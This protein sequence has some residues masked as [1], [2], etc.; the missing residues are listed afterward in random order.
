L[1]NRILLENYF[2]Q[3]DLENQINNFIAYWALLTTSLFCK[4]ARKSGQKAVF[5][6]RI[7]GIKLT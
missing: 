7:S 6:R 2:L 3:G 1:K 5:L 4:A